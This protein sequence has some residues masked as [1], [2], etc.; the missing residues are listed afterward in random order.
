[1]FIPQG[2]LTAV[3][4][5]IAAL[6]VIAFIAYMRGDQ[7]LLSFISIVVALVAIIV[8][9]LIA[10]G[11]LII[12][13]NSEFQESEYG[14]SRESNKYENEEDIN[15]FE[16]TEASESVSESESS[17]D[18]LGYLHYR[19]HTYTTVR[20]PFEYAN[21][22]FFYNR[23][24]EDYGGHLAIIN[25]PNENN[26]LYDYVSEF[27]N[28]K[29]VYFG[30]TDEGHKGDWNWVDGSP[31]VYNNWSDGQPDNQND[32]DYA[33]F[34]HEDI[35][36]TWRTGDFSINPGDEI[37]VLIEWDEDLENPLKIRTE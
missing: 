20:L 29:S 34:F 37:E 36:G 17:I 4:I 14:D 3:I 35:P 25:E 21:S 27:S 19:G 12:H 26:I 5:I 7:P 10:N 30:L 24:F 8:T 9:V 31:C 18:E 22:F 6:L 11:K 28:F 1:M 32:N 16:N 23:S 33:L 15:L 13:N 2:L